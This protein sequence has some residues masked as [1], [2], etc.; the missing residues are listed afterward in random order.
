MHVGKWDDNSPVGI[1]A[2]FEED[3]SFI[4]VCQYS[5]G[6]KNGKGISLDENGNVVVSRY[7]DGE[8]VSERVIEDTEP[9]VDL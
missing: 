8:L 1:G 2:R 5:G 7:I 3:G 9:P 6:V 4:D